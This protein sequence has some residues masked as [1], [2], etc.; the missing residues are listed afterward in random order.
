MDNRPP[1]ITYEIFHNAHGDVLAYRAENWDDD[2][3][4]EWIAVVP[5]WKRQGNRDNWQGYY[6][7]WSDAPPKLGDMAS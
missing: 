4:G 7:T 5:N 6:Q 2:T 3:L 1:T